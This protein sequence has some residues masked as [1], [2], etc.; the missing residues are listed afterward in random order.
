MGKENTKFVAAAVQ[1]A[2]VFL[3][4]EETIGKAC[5]LIEEA[6]DNG[7]DLIVFPEAFIPDRKSTRLNSSHIQ[8][9][10]MPSSA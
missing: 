3:N 6:R 7:A 2:P 9:S 1:T 4:K 8:K 10:R 5:S